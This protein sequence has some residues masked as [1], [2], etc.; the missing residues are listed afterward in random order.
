F[1]AALTPCS[2]ST[3][4]SEGHSA[5]CNSCRETSSPGRSR[6]CEGF[7][8]TGPED[9]IANRS[10][11]VPGSLSP[12]QTKRSESLM[13]WAGPSP[14]WHRILCAKDSIRASTEKISRSREV[15]PTHRGGFGS[16]QLIGFLS[17]V[18]SI[19][20]TSELLVIRPWIVDPN[21]LVP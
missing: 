5:R 7:G 9:A 18:E 13:A 16:V 4:V 2:K 15:Q 1:T 14:A 19:R 20:M 3:K 21:L 12:L 10:F 8:K 17:A 6:R 11:S